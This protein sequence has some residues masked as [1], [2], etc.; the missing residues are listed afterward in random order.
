M[1]AART[2]TP[3]AELA[4]FVALSTWEEMPRTVVA[5]AQRAIADGM[6]ATALGSGGPAAS[7]AFVAVARD[8]GVAEAS[9]IG[10]ARRLPAPFAAQ[11]NATAARDGGGPGTS[12]VVVASAL[13]LAEREGVRGSRLLLGV[14]LGLEVAARVGA[15]LGPSHLKRGYDLAGTAARVGG[16]AAAGS[17]LGLTPEAVLSSFGYAA[18]T[19]GGLAASPPEIRSLVAGLA[20]ADAIWAALLGGAGLVGPPFPLEGRRGLLALES[21]L[22]DA[23]QLHAGLGS[24]WTLTAASFGAVPDPAAGKPWPEVRG[25]EAAESVAA[26]VGATEDLVAR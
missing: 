11:V 1:T 10:R 22:P 25:L 14:A 13:A 9:V 15:A 4:A 20:A 8:G 26:L 6:I 19:A 2:G 21:A 5:L 18:T 24:T 7:A 12:S 23:T 3:S 17:L 16:A